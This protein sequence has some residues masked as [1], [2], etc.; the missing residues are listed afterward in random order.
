MHDTSIMHDWYFAI[1]LTVWN[2]L[3]ALYILKPRKSTL[4]LIYWVSMLIFISLY[5]LALLGYSIQ[6]PPSAG[7]FLGLAFMITIVFSMIL[8]FSVCWVWV[9]RRSFLE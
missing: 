2:I 5:P 4:R 1:G 8:F 3:F 7:L 6:N 9:I